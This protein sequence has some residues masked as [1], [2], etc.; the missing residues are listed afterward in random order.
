MTLILRQIDNSKAY[1][2][3]QYEYYYYLDL[4][5]E[6]YLSSQNNRFS[7]LKFLMYE[8]NLYPSSAVTLTK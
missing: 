8:L 1:F 4:N 6:N 7:S 5:N 3:I 2:D